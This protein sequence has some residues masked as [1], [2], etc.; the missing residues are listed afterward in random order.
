MTLIVNIEL[1]ESF[2]F[3]ILDILNFYKST[4]N[5]PMEYNNEVLKDFMGRNEPRT[6]EII[7]SK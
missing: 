6:W 3:A 2:S 7:I 4:K 1:N 5:N